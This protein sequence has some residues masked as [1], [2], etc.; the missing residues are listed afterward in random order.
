MV[1][2]LKVSGITVHRWRKFALIIAKTTV[3][4][5]V[6]GMGLSVFLVGGEKLYVLLALLTSMVQIW[7]LAYWL[8]KDL[9]IYR[10]RAISASFVGLITSALA[11][12]AVFIRF[13]L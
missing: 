2:G 9:R 13:I 11:G 6:I 5:I 10:I 3:L 12:S 1:W 8:E 7:P 4:G